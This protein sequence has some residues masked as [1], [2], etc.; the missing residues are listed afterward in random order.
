M[1]AHTNLA[2]MKNTM[3][4]TVLLVTDGEKKNAIIKLASF[5]P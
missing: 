1:N 5:A 4:N 2:M 3:Q